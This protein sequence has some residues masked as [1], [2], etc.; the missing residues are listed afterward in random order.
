MV[1]NLQAN[2]V[3]EPC[4]CL[5]WPIFLSFPVSVSCYNIK[6]SAW[7]SGSFHSHCACAYISE[8][9]VLYIGQLQDYNIIHPA[10]CVC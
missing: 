4:S 7:Q 2:T 9:L 8:H 5:D 10:E 3:S 1:H 6:Y